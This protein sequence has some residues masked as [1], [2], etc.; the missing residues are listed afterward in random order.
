MV[1]HQ[2]NV[3]RPFDILGDVFETLR[4]HGSIFFCSELAAPWGL[5]LESAGTPRFH[6]ALTGNCYVGAKAGE[7]LH[8][9]S[10]NIVLFPNGPAHWIADQPGRPLVAS[11]RAGAACEL[12]DPF[13]Q[14][15]EITHRLMCGLVRY[16]RELAHPLLDA[17]PHVMHF[18]QFEETDPI[19]L[20]VM[21]IEAQMRHMH[22]RRNPI[23]DRL[24]EALFL[25]LFN[26]HVNHHDD[27]TGFIA[28]LRDRRVYKAL[29]SIH[30]HPDV[31]WSLSSLSAKAG[32]S[33][34]SLVRRFRD[35]IGMA[36]MSYVTHW[37]LMKAYNLIKYSQQPLERIAASV[38]FSSA[39]TLSRA[40]ERHYGSRP[41]ALRRTHQETKS[42]A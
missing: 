27:V 10:R 22:D 6:I 21:L 12:G 18:P 36:P 31:A 39:R 4:F 9:R 1:S 14:Q 26:E 29:R 41:K 32:M 17:L 38:G 37:R 33:P 23:V 30:R 24:A 34:A 25:Q 11:E 40:F 13:F 28:A 8:V 3:G 5:A 19:W 15:G 42:S 16:D 7:C 20:T 35:V 2:I